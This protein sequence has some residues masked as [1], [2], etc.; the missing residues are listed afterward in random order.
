MLARHARR[1]LLALV[2][3]VTSAHAHFI[4]RAPDSWMSQGGLGGPQKVGPCGEEGGGTA[5]GKVTAFRPGETISIT[6]DEVIMHPGHYRVALAVN[7]RSELPPPPEVTASNDDPCATAEIQ[8]PPVFP[9][10]ADYLLPHTQAFSGPQTFTVT[11]PSDVTCTKCTLQVVEYMSSHPQPCFYYH[12]ADISISG[13]PIPP[14]STTTTTS[15]CFTA[16]CSV[17]AALQ[18][19]ACASDS[20]PTAMQR[21][22][23]RVADLLERAGTSAPRKAS[24]LRG[25]AKRLLTR[26][27]NAALRKPRLSESCGAAIKAMADQLAAEL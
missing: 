8:D 11:L 12:C 22:L 25:K 1:A 26:V 10:L 19:S 7:D 9:V 6:I 23:Q 15:P 18:G 4:L 2:L 24:A 13:E 17:D 14:G 27:G 21:K 5:T 3:A 16:R 20:V